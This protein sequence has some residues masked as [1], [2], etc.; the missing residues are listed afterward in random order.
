M[1]TRMSSS[2]ARRGLAAPLIALTVLASGCASSS[3]PVSGPSG[4]DEL[5]IPTPSPDPVDFVAGIDNPWL[6]LV[7]GAVWEYAVS[8]EDA[9]TRT[10]TVLE[11]GT[12][13]AGVGVTAV[14]EA[15]VSPGGTVVG[16]SVDYFAQDSAGNVWLFGHDEAE[17][18]GPGSWR[19]GVGGAEA[20][21]AMA[22]APRLGDGYRQGLAPGTAEDVARVE[23]VEATRTTPAGAFDPVVHVVV[24]TSLSTEEVDRYYARGVGLVQ[25]L[26]PAATV[27]LTAVP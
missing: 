8:G 20:G 25:E 16:S 23:S 4:V 11:A 18:A 15:A 19:A 24:T 3:P 5:E 9:G 21:L 22:A 12:E 7:P 26:T 2:R 13:I 14:R 6:P 10:V 27:S 17:P 1:L